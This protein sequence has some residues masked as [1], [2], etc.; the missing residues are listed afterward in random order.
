MP[1]PYSS[2]F[3]RL[4]IFEFERVICGQ[5]QMVDEK[6]LILKGLTVVVIDCSSSRRS[7]GWGSERLVAALD[8]LI[9][10]LIS[11]SVLWSMSARCKHS[12]DWHLRSLVARVKSVQ[13]QR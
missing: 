2:A 7:L 5:T 6:L 1:T 8:C 12:L 11:K 13:L 9:D 10:R 3:T 4:V